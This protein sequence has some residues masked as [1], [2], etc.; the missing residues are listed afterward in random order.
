MICLLLACAPLNEPPH[1]PSRDTGAHPPTEPIE[2]VPSLSGLPAWQ[3]P[4]PEAS[5]TS[6][7]GPRWVDD[8]SEFHLGIDLH[9]PMG[10]PVLA[11]ADGTVWRIRPSS[12]AS[13]PNTLYLRHE[14]EPVSFHGYEIIEVFS[15]YS[16][17]DTFE[18]QA[19][20]Q[21][22]QAGQLIATVGQSGQTAS[23]HLHFEV[24][25][26]TWCTLEYSTENP[27]SSCAASYDPSI[28]PLHVIPG[29]ET[30]PLGL[31]HLG[32]SRYALTTR[33]GDLD[34][35][36]LTTDLGTLD[37]DLRLGWDAT[38]EDRLD[39]Q[40][41]GWVFVQ[42]TGSADNHARW[43]LELD[44]SWLEVTDIHGEGVR[45]EP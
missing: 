33:P 17:I 35:S 26:G 22:V 41:L 13:D 42:P 21:F 24:R 10:T 8:R 37:L 40:D 6:G 4:V 1:R 15:V 2:R 32:D 11:P 23:P 44:A 27:D 25:L 7:F 29:R 12:S 16:H 36:R 31:E 19:E 43:E 5:T 30:Q 28:N 9:A 45:L 34:W 39:Q 20:D 14:V 3:H 38:D 18:V